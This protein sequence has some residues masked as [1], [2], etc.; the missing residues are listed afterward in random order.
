[1]EVAADALATDAEVCRLQSVHRKST[2]QY[3]SREQP[4][5]L[6]GSVV[7]PR[8]VAKRNSSMNEYSNKR[9]LF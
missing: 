6:Q 9:F 5:G 1:M 4:A 8:H 2:E 3:R 7:R